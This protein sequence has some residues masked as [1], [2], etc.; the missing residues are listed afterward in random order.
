M[1]VQMQKAV[2]SCERCIQHDGA[3]AKAPL[4]AIMVISPF[5]L[6]HVDFTSIETMMDLDKPPD[7]VNVLVFCDH[8]MR[9][10]MTYVTLIRLQNCC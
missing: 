6:L 7:V 4:Q 10:I 1:A 8:S 5:V 3:Q 2:S 9:H